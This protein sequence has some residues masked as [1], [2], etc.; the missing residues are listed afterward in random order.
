MNRFKTHRRLTSAALAIAVAGAIVG[1]SVGDDAAKNAGS[2]K[3]SKARPAAHDRVRPMQRFPDFKLNSKPPDDQYSGKL[4]RLSQDFPLEPLGVADDPAVAAILKIPYDQNDDEK[5]WLKYL[6]AVRDYCFEGNI[7]LRDAPPETAYAD[8]WQRESTFKNWF[9]VPWQHSGDKGREGI[10][11]LTR[12]ASTRAGQLGPEQVHVHD[13]HAVAVYNRIGG[14]TIGQVWKDQFDPNPHAAVFKA[15]TVVVKV[16][17]TQAGE[18]EV[19]YLHDG[20]VWKA[21]VRDPQDSTKK[22]VQNLRL[23]QMDVMV[24]DPRADKTGGWVFGTYCYNGS[25]KAENKWR[26]LVPVGIQWGNDPQ[27]DDWQANQDRTSPFPTKRGA[28][29]HLTQSIINDSEDLPPQHLGWG[30]R[31]NGPAD[32]Y[33]SSCM[34]CHATAQYPG[35]SPQHP[36]FKSLGH[37]PGDKNWMLWFRNLKCGE[38][39]NSTDPK[40]ALTTDFS[41]Q[42][43]IGF[44]NFYTWKSS[45]M[46]GYFTFRDDT[47]EVLSEPAN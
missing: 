3:P 44:E 14:Y 33:R 30:G 17:F 46:G 41:L 13:T 5:N 22:K 2:S 37:E 1:G 10:H 26:R 23:L 11:G 27:F 15:G 18:D 40:R 45:V 16:L 4:F 32:Y 7:D 47:H 12:E 6:T 43:Q 25:V 28:Q 9:H 24:R 34:S 36:D 8:D 19:P 42:L 29:K 38:S 35:H 21:Y 20:L 31:L 39:F